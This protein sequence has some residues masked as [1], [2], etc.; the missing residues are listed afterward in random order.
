MTNAHFKV[1]FIYH[2]PSDI[3]CRSGF[4]E[5][6]ETLNMGLLALRRFQDAADRSVR[7]SLRLT[8]W[9]FFFM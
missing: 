2:R 6:L 4:Q 9:L 7:M 5:G 8:A 3:F 1:H